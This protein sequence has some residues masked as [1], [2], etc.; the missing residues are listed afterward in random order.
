L[1]IKLTPSPTCG[2]VG[3]IRYESP[4]KTPG[5]RGASSDSLQIEFPLP[6]AI[7]AWCQPVTGPGADR[8]TTHGICPRH[9]RK[10]RFDLIKSA[11]K[12]GQ[13]VSLAQFLPAT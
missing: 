9:L 8:T 7:C 10:M 13:Y 2:A 4:Q 5:R 6:V 1:L 11:Q 3:L 12:A